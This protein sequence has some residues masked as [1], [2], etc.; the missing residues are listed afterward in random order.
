[1]DPSQFSATIENQTILKAIVNFLHKIEE[2]THT[3]AQ[4]TLECK[5][6]RQRELEFW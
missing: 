5:T 3:K 4:A 2:K 1:M 6:T